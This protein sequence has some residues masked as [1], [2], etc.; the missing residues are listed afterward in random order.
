MEKC[1]VCCVHVHIFC[2]PMTYAEI[3]ASL[4]KATFVSQ[5]LHCVSYLWEKILLCPS[6][7]AKKQKMNKLNFVKYI[8]LFSQHK[9][10]FCEKILRYDFYSSYRETL[11]FDERL[12]DY[13][14][15]LMGFMGKLMSEC[16]P[17]KRNSEV[18]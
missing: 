15:Q 16:G 8:L 10:D 18:M 7:T 6:T 3:K 13:T 17:L 11:H 4:L 5:N 9:Q 1:P 2:S 12:I 14:K